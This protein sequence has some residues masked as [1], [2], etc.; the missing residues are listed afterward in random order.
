MKNVRI[1]YKGVAWC[2]RVT[3]KQTVRVWLK[4]IPTVLEG[5][6]ENYWHVSEKVEKLEDG[7]DIWNA[8]FIDTLA[9]RVWVNKVKVLLV[10]TMIGDNYASK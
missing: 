8:W 9:L 6:M 10:A 5:L 1:L 4:L 3:G 2:L 7:G